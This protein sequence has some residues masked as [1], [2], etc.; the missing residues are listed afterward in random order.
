MAKNLA[1]DPILAAL[2]Q[3]WAPKLFF[4]WILPLLDV[5][6]SRKLSLY[7][8]LTKTN[9][10]NLRKWQ[11]NLV[12]DLI[13]A[14]LAQ[15]QAANFFSSKIWLCQSLDTM[16]S[17]HHVQYQ[18]NIRNINITIVEKTKLSDGRADGQTKES[19]FIGRC[20]THV[21]RPKEN[22]RLRLNTYYRIKN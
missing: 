7:A 19:D 13:L 1:L 5:R 12:S 2:V 14:H 15:I 10:P 16:V 3:M 20:P 4:S 9:E 8:I 6:Q 21:E 17:Y 18:K 22:C 11:K